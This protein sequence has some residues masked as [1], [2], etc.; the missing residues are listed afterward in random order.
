[1]GVARKRRTWLSDVRR[2]PECQRPGN[3]Y[4]HRSNPSVV[5][6]VTSG[7]IRPPDAIGLEG[8]VD[9]HEGVGG[10]LTSLPHGR[11]KAGFRLAAVLRAVFEH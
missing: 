2:E 6:L 10:S 7:K 5:D 4:L 8:R 1:V 11:S 9:N 3:D